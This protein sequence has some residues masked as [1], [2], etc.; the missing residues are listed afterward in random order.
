MFIF[1][2]KKNRG[3]IKTNLLPEMYQKDHDYSRGKNRDSKNITNIFNVNVVLKI[4]YFQNNFQGKKCKKYYKYYIFFKTY[5]LEKIE[6][7]CWRYQKRHDYDRVFLA[8]KR[9]GKILRMS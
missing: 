7:L 3:G 6:L 8:I 5:F 2:K 4:L 9:G 1:S